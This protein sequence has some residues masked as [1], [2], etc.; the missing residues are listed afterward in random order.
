MMFFSDV[1]SHIN[2]IANIFL[3]LDLQR[4]NYARFIIICIEDHHEI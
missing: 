3:R 1:D 2:P 4:E